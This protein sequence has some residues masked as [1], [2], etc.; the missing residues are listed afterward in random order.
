MLPVENPTAS[1]WIEGAD[2]PLRNAR[3]T[4]ELPKETD[5][6]IVGSGYTGA[7]LAY[8]LHKLRPHFYS[9]YTNWSQRFGAEGALD[10]IRHEAAHLTAFDKVLNA[11]GIAQK[12]SFKLGETFDAA[13]SD[14]AWTRLKGEYERMR[15]DHGPDGDCIK[16]CRL[17]EDPKEAEEFTQM[18]GWPYKFVHAILDIVLATG[19]LNL[20]ANT[21][22]QEVS[23]RG[24]DGLITVKTARGEIKAKANRWASHLLPEFKNL[25]FAGRGT[26]AAIKAPEG[27]IK[28][29]GAQHWDSNYHLQLPP[30]H[31]TII[32]GGAKPLTVH[33]PAQYVNNDREDEQFKGVPEFYAG[34]PKR[35]VLGW[36]GEDPA[37]F[38]KETNEGGVW[39]GV[40]SASI[41]SFPFVGPVPD[42]EGMPR[43]LGTT[44][45]LAPLVLA[46]L[47]FEG[48]KP[49]TAD[50]FPPL[51]KPFLVTKERVDQLQL[52]NL[53]EKLKL[54]IEGDKLSAKKIFAAPLPKIVT[55]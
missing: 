5:L 6:V 44:A 52:S 12:V 34:W 9:R 45:H 49:V 54:D 33:D 21:P 32:I 51:P 14:E 30:P 39:S 16:D 8:W 50:I 20:Q 19:H 2:S 26:I 41:D 13:M 28:R 22:V 3:T 38:E 25:I 4:E 46:E 36:K 23:E 27:F 24:A 47:G 11:E 15:A 18:K 7:S 29:S 42:K 43:I 48:K 10:V 17:I 40:Y 35:D 1:Y 37:P 55:E 53:L 31:N